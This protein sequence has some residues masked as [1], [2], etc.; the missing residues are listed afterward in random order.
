MKEWFAN[1]G[2]KMTGWDSVGENAQRGNAAQ[3]NEKQATV[4][5]QARRGAASAWSYASWRGLRR[6]GCE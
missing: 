1:H 2:G 4:E 6:K 3:P 5:D